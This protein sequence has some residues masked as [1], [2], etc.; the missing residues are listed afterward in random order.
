MTVN[1][2]NKGIQL[3]ILVE[4][5]MNKLMFLVNNLITLIILKE[6][7]SKISCMIQNIIIIQRMKTIN[8][9]EYIE[10]N[11]CKI[12]STNNNFKKLY[13]HKPITL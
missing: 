12:T 11:T 8:N 7:N 1:L 5:L 4:N 10:M 3:K 13:L 2:K 9:E 6:L